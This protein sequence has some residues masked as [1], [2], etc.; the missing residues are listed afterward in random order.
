MSQSILSRIV[1]TTALRQ[2]REGETPKVTNMELFFDLVYVFSIIQLSHYLLA[3]QTWLGALQFATVFAAVWWAWNYTAWSTNWLNPD[4][5]AGRLLMIFLM[6]CALLM[7]VA[8]PYAFTT[9]AALFVGAYVTMA[10][11]R[12]GY[13]AILFRGQKMG[14]NYA[15]LCAWSAIS[16]LFWVLGVIIPDIR[17][18]AWLG[19]VIIDY[20]AP[21]TGFWLPGAGRTPMSSW[22]LAGLHL[23]ERNQ[24]V[25]II[26]LGESILLLGGT[27]IGTSLTMPYLAAASIGFLIIVSLWWLYFVHTTTKGE[28]AF[29]ENARDHTSLA[30]SSLAYSHGIMVGGA[31][32]IAVAIEQIIAHPDTAVHLPTILVGTAGPIIYL[33]GSVLFIRSATTKTPAWHLYAVA[34]ILG[35]GWVTYQ[36]HASGLTLGISILTVLI[37]LSAITTWK[38]HKSQSI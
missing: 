27:L 32:V 2:L 16:G 24:Q 1:P 21:Y 7:A 13:M 37:I 34:V 23:L 9:H 29:E 11:V 3:H 30:R 28:H 18:A 19:A 17:T 15:Q 25:Y 14:K 8:I 26:A 36:T 10:L 22:P 31:I 20:A 6:G 35:I 12:A 5:T 4:H 33:I 38:Q